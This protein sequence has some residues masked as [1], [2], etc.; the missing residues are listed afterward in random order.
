[1]DR[2]LYPGIGAQEKART[3]NLTEEAAMQRAKIMQAMRWEWTLSVAAL[4][5]AQSQLAGVEFVPR[6]LGEAG[7][8]DSP[9][10][11]SIRMGLE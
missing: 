4:A 8:A 3:G 2:R 11:L 1:M 9:W 10:R 7:A 5:P 6:V